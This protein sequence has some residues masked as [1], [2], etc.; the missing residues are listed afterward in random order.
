[1][2]HRDYAILPEIECF[3]GQLSQVWMNL[4]V[5]AAQAMNGHGE[6]RITTL[7]SGDQVVVKIRDNG[8]GI[9]EDVL[10]RI[11]TPSLRRSP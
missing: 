1:M 3:A 11:L 9:P 8:P 6:I 7:R 10:I 2:L 4:L 5:N